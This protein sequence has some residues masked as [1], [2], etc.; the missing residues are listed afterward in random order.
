MDAQTGLIAVLVASLFGS[1]HC[2][3]MCGPLVVFALGSTE[4]ASVWGRAVLQLAY[5]GGRLISY[6]VLGA[7]C[8]LVGA[9]LDLS[10]SMVG[11]NRVAALLAGGMMVAVG[12]VAILRY[13]GVRL[14]ELPVPGWLTRVIALGQRAAVGLRPF[15]RAATIGLL[16]ALLPCGWLYMFA[17]VAAG[18]SSVWWGAAVMAA[19]WLGT[20]PVLASLGLGVQA[21]TS[22]VGKRIP[23]I[24]ALAIVLLGLYTIGG[25]LMMPAQ[26][27]EPAIKPAADANVADQVD[28]LR[29]EVPPCCRHHAGG[30]SDAPKR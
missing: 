21:L 16:S 15:P 3:G 18:T 6:G 29:D 30:D 22:T 7:V 10:G 11:L 13:G 25:R 19:F 20:V 17:I 9:A 1:L 28:A 26:A 8:G 23:L 2:A 24:T 14:P 4:A 27:L 12:I 5:H